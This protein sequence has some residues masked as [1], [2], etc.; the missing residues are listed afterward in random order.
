[1]TIDV[2]TYETQADPEVRIS[3]L[4]CWLIPRAGIVRG[5]HF[6]RQDKSL[7][8]GIFFSFLSMRSPGFVLPCIHRTQ[9]TDLVGSRAKSA[10]QNWFETFVPPNGANLF[11]AL[12]AEKLAGSHI[13]A[14]YDNEPSLRRASQRERGTIPP[15]IL[16]L[17]QSGTCQWWHR[18]REASY[19]DGQEGD[20][21]AGEEF[22]QQME[23]P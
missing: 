8:Y 6:T 22:G 11:L 2:P 13:H 17:G 20:Q 3:P 9:A 7:F 21:L 14:S 15:D 19:Q 1:M 4:P 16:W 12:R 10:P 5:C 23:V 18:H